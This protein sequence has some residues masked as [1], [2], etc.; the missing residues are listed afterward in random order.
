M[1]KA[2]YKPSQVACPHTWNYV[3]LTEEV[4]AKISKEKWPKLSDKP[5]VYT[6]D[7][8]EALEKGLRSRLDLESG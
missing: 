8:R 6:V 4:K 3:D 1:Y 2:N 5:P 7:K